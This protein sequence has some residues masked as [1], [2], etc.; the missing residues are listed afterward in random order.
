[1]LNSEFAPEARLAQ[2]L[3]DVRLILDTAARRGAKTPFSALHRDLLESL[4]ALGYGEE[5]NSAIIRAFAV[6]ER[7]TP[8]LPDS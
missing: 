5:D 3:K 6:G 2:H 4:V 7:E 1:M 8:E